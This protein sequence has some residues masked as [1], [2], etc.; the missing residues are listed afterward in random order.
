MNNF[1]NTGSIFDQILGD[2]SNYTDKLD[3]YPFKVRCGV[4]KYRPPRHE[5]FEFIKEM[6]TIFIEPIFKGELF[7]PPEILTFVFPEAHMSVHEEREF[8]VYLKNH[9]EV[10]KI[11]QIDILTKSPMLISSFS[12]EMIRIVEWESDKDYVGYK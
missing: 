3:L 6:G 11:K 9:P 7:D 4:I 12:R 8:T 10:D 2:I 5:F 1:V